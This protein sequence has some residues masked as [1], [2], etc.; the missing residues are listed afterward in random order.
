MT[1]PNKISL[2]TVVGVALYLL[3]FSLTEVPP[4]VEKTFFDGGEV[5]IISE[6][7]KASGTG[8]E[9]HFYKSGRVEKI[10]RFRGNVQNGLESHFY[11]DGKRKSEIPYLNGQKHGLM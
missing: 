3:G 8:R 11:P 2:F 1:T 10:L 7:K 5:K 6:I 4:A 9:I